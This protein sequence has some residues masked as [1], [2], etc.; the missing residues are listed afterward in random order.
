MTG[1]DE[2]GIQLTDLLAPWI[3]ILISISAAFWF[4]DF[5]TN[6]MVGLKYRSNSHFNEGDHVILDGKDAIIV[7]FGMR[8]TTFGLYTDRGYVWR[9]IPNDRLP[10]HLDTDEEKGK[11]LQAMI[12]K[13]QD[14]KISNNKKD[15]ENLKKQ[16]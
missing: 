7:K 15:I 2:L 1:F 13:S 6:L 9:F 3:A 10:T 4:K 16:D 14:E 11:R 12:D 5:A 8:E